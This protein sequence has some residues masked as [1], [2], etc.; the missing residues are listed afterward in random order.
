MPE[1]LGSKVKVVLSDYNYKRDLENRLLMAE[2]SVFDIEVLR[3]ILDSSLKFPLKQLATQVD[4]SEKA[5]LPILDKFSQSQ[6]IRLHDNMIHVDKEMRK[7]YEAQI[8]KFNPQF[9]PDFEFLQALL[10]NIPIHILPQ[11][12]SL[13]DTLTHIFTSIVQTFFH[14]PKTYERYLNTLKME[15]PIAQQ[16]KNDLFALPNLT[17]SAQKIMKKYALSR[18]EFEKCMLQLELHLVCC[19]SYQ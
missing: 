4:L 5:L 12:Y 11:W 19:L 6:L 9:I 2:L 8:L 17:L 14:A 16:I 10:S 18:E 3:E 1:L 13:P 15:C 7:Y